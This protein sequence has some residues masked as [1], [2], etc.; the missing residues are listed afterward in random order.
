MRR[1]RVTRN[2]RAKTKAPGMKKMAR[3]DDDNRFVGGVQEL[4]ALLGRWSQRTQSPSR[5]SSFC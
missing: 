1:R 2:L 4:K 5:L 3:S